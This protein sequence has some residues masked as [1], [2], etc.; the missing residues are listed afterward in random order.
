MSGDRTITQ[1]LQDIEADVATIKSQLAELL[2]LLRPDPTPPRDAEITA[3]V[4]ALI[5]GLFDDKPFELDIVGG[6]IVRK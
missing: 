5:D 4:D 2:T 1:R 3:D 6:R